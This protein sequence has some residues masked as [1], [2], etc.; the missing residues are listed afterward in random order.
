[1]FNSGRVPF[2]NSQKW[3]GAVFASCQ[4]PA[5]SGG[6][7]LLLWINLIFTN[8]SRPFRRGAPAQAPYS[9]PAG[10]RAGDR[11]IRWFQ[12]GQPAPSHGRIE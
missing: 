3:K 11:V 12:Q 1:M 4:S 5:P 7:P 2:L 8:C 10:F 6:E 9:P